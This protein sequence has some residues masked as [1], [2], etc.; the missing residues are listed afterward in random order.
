MDKY[1][2]M[3]LNKYYFKSVFDVSA[4]KLKIIV[5]SLNSNQRENLI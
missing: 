1:T 2:M 3:L 4:T 5:F